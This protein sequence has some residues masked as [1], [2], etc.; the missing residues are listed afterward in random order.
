[1]NYAIL[2]TITQEEEENATAFIELLWE[3]LRKLHRGSANTKD[4]FITQSAVDISRKLQKLA[5]GPEQSL[6]SLL[7]LATSVFYNRDQ[8]EQSERDRRDKRK[9]TA[10]VMAFRQA[11]PRGSEEGK[12]CVSLQSGRTCYHCSLP[13]HFKKNCPQRNGPPTCPQPVCQGDHWKARNP[14]G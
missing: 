12:A 1:M 10:L 14:R 6:E 11:D 13:G 4:K 8:Q 7:N 3:A 9:A 5:L 2:S